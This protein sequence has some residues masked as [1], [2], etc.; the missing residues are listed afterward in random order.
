[1]VTKLLTALTLAAGVSAMPQA[2]DGTAAGKVK[3][4]I[5]MGQV[6]KSYS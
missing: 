4:F 3:V 6:R 1:M 5:M 2:P